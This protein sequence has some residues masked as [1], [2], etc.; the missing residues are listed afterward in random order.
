MTILFLKYG[1]LEQYLNSAL[2]AV[3]APEPNCQ[4]D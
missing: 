1:I 3:G 2:H 4:P